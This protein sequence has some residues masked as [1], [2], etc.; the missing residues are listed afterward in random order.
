MQ[1]R[2][3]FQGKSTQ[4]QIISM[5]TIINKVLETNLCQAEKSGKLYF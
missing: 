4:A 2:E 3:S 1:M 5:I